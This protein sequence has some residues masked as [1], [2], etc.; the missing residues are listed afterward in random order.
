MSQVL[1]LKRFV[2]DMVRQRYEKLTDGVTFPEYLNLRPYCC[3]PVRA[4]PMSVADAAAASIAKVPWNCSACTL[5]NDPVS[6]M[7]PC[8]GP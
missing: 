6:R 4:R 2:V 5:L 7:V 8:R 1:H 3:D